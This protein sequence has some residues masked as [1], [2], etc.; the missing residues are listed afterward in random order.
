MTKKNSKYSWSL[1]EPMHIEKND[2][3]YDKYVNQLKQKGF[4]DTETWSLDYVVSAF[5]LPR[6]K[7][8]KQVSNGYPPTL[9]VKQWNKILDDMI[10]AF[11]W[12]INIDD[13]YNLTQKEQE[14]N[15]D[16]HRKGLELFAKYFRELWW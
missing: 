8:F 3:H 9:T 13:Q 12:N 15:W 16:K 7:R 10:F 4:S 2:K 6:L 5:I 14:K 11:E 1:K